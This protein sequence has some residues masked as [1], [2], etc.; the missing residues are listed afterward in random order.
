MTVAIKPF[1]YGF[2]LSKSLQLKRF[3]DRIA[4]PKD[5]NKSKINS[6]QMQI[7]WLT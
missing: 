7:M 6:K 2:N 1:N 3:K 4:L 5:N